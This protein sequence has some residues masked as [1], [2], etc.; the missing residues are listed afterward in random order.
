MGFRRRGIERLRAGRFALRHRAPV[1][2]TKLE[3]RLTSGADASVLD[4]LGQSAADV[5]LKVRPRT[6]CGCWQLLVAI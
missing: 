4:E 1:D 2:G 3:L 6:R 5:C